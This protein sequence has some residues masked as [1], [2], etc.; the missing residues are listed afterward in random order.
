MLGDGLGGT[1]RTLKSFDND[2]AILEVNI[3]QPQVAH[4]RGP[5]TV[6]VCHNDHGPFPSALGFCR[7]EHREDFCWFE[8]GANI[9]QIWGTRPE[10]LTIA[11]AQGM[12]FVRDDAAA[13][14]FRAPKRLMMPPTC[15]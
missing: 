14:E 15:S 10:K 9:R 6:F 3:I 12:C 11:Q 4:F 5:H 13:Q 7:P 8:V 1:E 2:A